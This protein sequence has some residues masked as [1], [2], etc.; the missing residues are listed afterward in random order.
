M[1]LLEIL[2]RDDAPP[3]VKQIII[4]LDEQLISYRKQLEE[5]LKTRSKE[6]ELR[7]K[8]D[9]YRKLFESAPD[10]VVLLEPTDWVID[11]NNAALIL[12]GSTKVELIGRHFSETKK[13]HILSNYPAMQ[14]NFQNLG[15]LT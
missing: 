15:L 3:D 12:T 7:E 11:C 8:E 9:L 13:M 4:D 14:I 10:I 1:G 5:L 6:N 2:A